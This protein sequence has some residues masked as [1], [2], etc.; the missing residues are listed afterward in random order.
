MNESPRPI[1]NQDRS[2]ILRLAA[3]LADPVAVPPARLAD[4]GVVQAHAAEI[5]A[6]LV[7]GKVP[8]LGLDASTSPAHAALAA[9]PAFQ[10]ARAAEQA[11]YDLQRGEF[12]TVAEAWARAAI[13]YVL[14]KSV[15]QPP[16]YPYRSDNQDVMVRLADGARAAAI[17]LDD[18]GYVE[19]K[20]V[21]EPHKYLFRRFEMGREVSAIHLHEWVGWGTAFL[22][23][24]PLFARART[25]PDDPLTIHPA[26]EEALLTTMA[27]AF[28]ENK[29]VKLSDLTKAVWLWREYPDFDWFLAE[30]L[31]VRRGWGDGFAACVLLWAGMERA[32][33][34]RCSIPAGRVAAADA[35]LA[36]WQREGVNRALLADPFKPTIG[37]VFSKRFYYA[38]LARDRAIGLRRKLWEGLLHTTAGIRRNIGVES[39]MGALI[40]LSGTDGSGKSTHAAALSAALDGCHI[41]NR[42]V[43]SRGGSSRATDAVLAVAKGLL[44]GRR[45]GSARQPERAPGA[46]VARRRALLRS[47]LL[48]VGWELVVAADL[49]AQ[50]AWRIW[51]PMRRGEVVIAD[52]YLF[53]TLAELS[54]YTEAPD[55]LDGPAARLLLALAPRP[56]IALWLDLPPEAA[57]ARARDAEDTAFLAA[58]RNRYATLAARGLLA[59]VDNG[60]DLAD[61]NRELVRRALRGYYADYRTLVNALFLFNPR[62]ASRDR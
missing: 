35:A 52:R 24:A 62:R 55:P 9:A 44:G 28:Y 43:W 17:L 58:Q 7:S 61:A 16:S 8:L 56:T 29:V 51:W 34:D 42:V 32:L 5:V 27:H 59:R 10:A 30:R 36:P 37:F 57:A 23:E 60:A 22:D 2:A 54:A 26:P 46:T 18:L 12:A 49:L 14:I 21:E 15:G 4:A 39:Q 3:A 20:N 45:A 1:S 38:K 40:T 11:H 25:A 31:A 19:V 41:R 53:D 50:W 6:R 33:Y 48:R 47:P 13:P